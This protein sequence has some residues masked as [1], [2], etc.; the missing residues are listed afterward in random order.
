MVFSKVDESNTF[1][2]PC[3]W[4]MGIQSKSRIRSAGAVYPRPG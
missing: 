1:V 3:T 2:E 4:I